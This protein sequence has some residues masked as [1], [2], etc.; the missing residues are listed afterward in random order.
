MSTK[1][2]D[3]PPPPRESQE[4]RPLD[5]VIGKHVLRTLGPPGDLLRVQVRQLWQDHYRANVFVGVDAASATIAHSYFLVAD[6]NGNI[7]AS[8][9]HLTREY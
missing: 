9:P 8:T 3:Q 7:L 4:R 5:A 2:Q 6:G 1:Q